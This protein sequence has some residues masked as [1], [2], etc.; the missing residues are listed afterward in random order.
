VRLLHS[1]SMTLRALVGCVLFVS[2]CGD[3]T[4]PLYA[5]RNGDIVFESDRTGDRDIYRMHADGSGLIRL[6]DS[7]YRDQHPAWSPDGSQI[8]F[9]SWRPPVG[10]YVMDA[11]GSNLRALQTE[12]MEAQFPSWSPDGRS[13]AFQ[14]NMAGGA[15]IWVINLE[16]LRVRQVTPTGIVAT[17]PAWSPDGSRIAFAGVSTIGIINADGSGLAYVSRPDN[18]VDSDPAW[19][20]DGLKIAFRR[21]VPVDWVT[22]HQSIWVMDSD[23]T[24]QIRL[25]QWTAGID[26]V[27][28]WSPDSRQI[29]FAHDVDQ[30][31]DI[32][33]MNADGSDA[34][35]ITNQ[36]G[37]NYRP[38]W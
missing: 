37:I 14:S 33:V 5:S 13:I 7:P 27:P 11:D 15:E 32:Y 6:T 34:R 36:P 22:A 21:Y 2:G 19:S 1:T 35:N 10:L 25:T 17:I 29:A 24:N 3:Y 20:P 31:F 16:N 9:F 8:A 30:N 23:G 4:G 38:S 12:A 28:T 26:F 18:A